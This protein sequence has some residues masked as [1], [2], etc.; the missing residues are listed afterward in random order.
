M[1][2]FIK[3][4]R[5]FIWILSKLEKIM[6]SLDQATINYRTSSPRII[7]LSPG[8]V[9]VFGSNKA[10]KHGAGA[11]KMAN[12]LF[13]APYGSGVGRINKLNYAIPTKGWQLEVLKLEEIKKFVDQFIDHAEQNWQETFL[14]TEI[15]CGLAGYTPEDIAPM[16]EKAVYLSNVHLPKSFWKILKP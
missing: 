16:F 5:P 14:V 11:A 10:G 2:N 1:K 4:F 9:F 6:G 13:G 3:R 8:E 7:M 12:D 15:G